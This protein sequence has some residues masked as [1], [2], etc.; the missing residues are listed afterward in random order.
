MKH[1]VLFCVLEWKEKGMLLV[2]IC[3]KKI[4]NFINNMRENIQHTEGK[5]APVMYENNSLEKQLDVGLGSQIMLE[6]TS[7]NTQHGGWGT[8]WSKV[9]L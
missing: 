1:S 6:T 9:K 4:Y 5:K 8:L 2:S 7:I 3:K